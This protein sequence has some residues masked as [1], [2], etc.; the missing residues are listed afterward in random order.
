MI[1][2]IRSGLKRS[3]NTDPDILIPVTSARTEF[4][5][6]SLAAALQ[7]EG[8][9]ARVFAGASNML[10]WEGGY[11]DPIKVMVRRVD[12]ERAAAFIR[13]LKQQSGSIDWA[14]VD[15]D[16]RATTIAPGVVCIACGNPLGGLP[17][18]TRD[19]PRCGAEVFAEESA[20]GTRRHDGEFRHGFVRR[21]SNFRRLGWILIAAGFVAPMLSPGLIIPLAV[22]VLIS[23]AFAASNRKH[24]ARK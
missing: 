14:N 16:E 6:N 13:E 9:P 7:A 20:S 19:C 5:G 21:W 11:T 3:L 24:H 22:I 8:I 2:A 12:A 17:A 18:D 10:Q 1:F 15:V 23:L 4:E